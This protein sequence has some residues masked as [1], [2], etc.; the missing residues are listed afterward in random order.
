MIKFHARKQ[1]I[2]DQ[3][4]KLENTALEQ[5]RFEDYDEYEHIMLKSMK[6]WRRTMRET[7]YD[8][9]SS[10]MEHDKNPLR[11]IKDFNTRHMITQVLA[12]MWCI[13]FSLM[14]GSWTVFGY[15]AVAHFVF[16]VAIFV[17]V[18]TFQVAEKKP[19]YFEKFNSKV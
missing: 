8:A 4:N 11:H 18:G 15:T 17:T 7:I 12:W 14:V 3:W 1:Y 19:E 9:Y 10:V 13:V 6:K 16:L 5:G 2:L